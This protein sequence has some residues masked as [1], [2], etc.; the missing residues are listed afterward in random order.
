ML[1]PTTNQF[2]NEF[3]SPTMPRDP[4]TRLNEIVVQSY[5]WNQKHH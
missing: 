1:P 2:Q 4:R 3:N 5:I